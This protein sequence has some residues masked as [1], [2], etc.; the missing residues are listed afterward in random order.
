MR[1]TLYTIL[2]APTQT[3]KEIRSLMERMDILAW[4]LIPGAIRYDLD[5]VQTS[6]VDRLA[7]A[8]GELDEMQRKLKKLEERKELEQRIIINLCD[9]IIGCQDLTDMERAI[10]MERYGNSEAWDEIVYWLDISA[11]HAFRLQ[12]SAL[13]KLEAF[14]DPYANKMQ[15][16]TEN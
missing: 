6:P 4:S 5:K 12:R 8:M 10:I 2:M 14:L 7:E 9:K 16:K 15:T 3:A 13:D 1:D 11:S